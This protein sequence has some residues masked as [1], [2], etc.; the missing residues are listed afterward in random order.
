[1]RSPRNRFAAAP[2]ILGFAFLFH[3][4]GKVVDIAGFAAE[5]AMP[6]IIAAAAACVQFGAGLLLILGLSN[7][8]GQPGTWW[9]DGSCDFTAD[10]KRRT[11]CQPSRSQL[12]GLVFL[13]GFEC[14]PDSAWSGFLLH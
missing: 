10:R 2:R 4:Y 6:Y 8:L 1:M 12:G 7:T 5:F 14:H 11:V 9:N 13:P 3:G